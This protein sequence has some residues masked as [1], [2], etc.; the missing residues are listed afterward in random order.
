MLLNVRGGSGAGK[1]HIGRGLLRR[2]GGEPIMGRTRKGKER[3][4]AQMLPGGL[5]MLGQYQVEKTMGG[6][7][8]IYK[9]NDERQAAIIDAAEKY[10]FVYYESLFWSSVVHRSVDVAEAVKPKHDHLYGF[11]DTP[12]DVCIKQVYE[13]NGGK[14]INENTIHITFKRMITVRRRLGEL[15]LTVV[16]I[17]H[18]R[19]VDRVDELFR[20]A[21]WSPD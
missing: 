13:R 19:S 21:G 2:Y 17:D 12:A 6:I 5:V 18:T 10:D 15:G 20:A 11:L 4:A 9:T 14:P 8:G 3:L 7:E 16:E 1:S